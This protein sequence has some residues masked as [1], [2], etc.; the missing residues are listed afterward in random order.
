M[1]ARYFVR[2]QTLDH[3]RT[4]WLGPAIEQYVGWLTERR[5]STLAKIDPLLLVRNDP[6]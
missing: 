3:I 4:L 5:T 6:D 2:P 1:L